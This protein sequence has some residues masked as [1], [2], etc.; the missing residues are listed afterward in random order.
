[1]E[2]RAKQPHRWASPAAL[3]IAAWLAGCLG[4]ALAGR[5]PLELRVPL[6]CALIVI[7]TIVIVRA[8][9]GWLGPLFLYDVIRTS[10]RGQPAGLRIFY[11]ALL[12]TMLLVVGAVEFQGRPFMDLMVGKAT[13]NTNELAETAQGFFV[14]IM[15]VQFIIILLVT[16]LYVAPAIAEEKERRS[17]EFLLTTELLDREIVLGML[18]A[19]LAN[20]L[21]LLLTGV[22]VLML[23]AFLGGVSPAQV[24]AAVILTGMTVLAL[25]SLSILS[26]TLSRTALVAIASTYA[27]TA[28]LFFPAS[29]IV[30]PALASATWEVLLG[31][32]ILYALF[33]GAIAIVCAIW[34]VN[35]MRP[36][37]L[38]QGDPPRIPSGIAR[39]AVPPLAGPPAAIP[40]GRPTTEV[41]PHNAA[42]RPYRGAEN[43]PAALQASGP[44]HRFVVFDDALRW[45]E[46]YAEQY[47]RP[48]SPRDF[49]TCLTAL[50]LIV[51]C[52]TAPMLTSRLLTGYKPGPEVEPWIRSLTIALTFGMMLITALN[53]AA[54][55]S[56][57]RERDT[58][59][60]LLLLPV[61]TGEILFTKWLG[62]MASVRW[63]LWG[64]AFLWALGVGSGGLD[65]CAV[66]LLAAAIGIYIGVTAAFGLWLSTLTTTLRATLLTVL[67]TLVLV[68]GPGN[69]VQAME[70]SWLFNAQRSSSWWA[71]ILDYS[72]T[73]ATVLTSLCYRDMYPSDAAAS[74]HEFSRAI[75]AKS[76][77]D[78]STEG[79]YSWRR[80]VYALVGLHIF[81]ALAVGLLCSANARIVASRGARPRATPR[82]Q[83]APSH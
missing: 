45:K 47:L 74:G 2:L 15:T 6:A 51:A 76:G 38:V 52:V 35:E 1:M 78:L 41:A 70:G 65:I 36:L 17:L 43:S 58:L 82:I 32:V 80:I 37:A 54:R 21:L 10:R 75:P 16:P 59:G 25:S 63:C 27:W 69:I 49:F 72:L 28:V 42:T 83:P 3:K 30:V 13:L 67:L 66:P 18:G 50:G 62:G 5:W 19:R 77:N 61:T 34:A 4:L 44:S 8:V 12:L 71:S 22:P 31:V 79:Y 68:A 33:Q 7:A 11:G 9:I 48:A 73:P 40:T 60:A 14:G 53:S 64:F 29:C 46:L 24:L 55:V 26:S 20:L 39:P 57:E 81:L 23:V 56:R